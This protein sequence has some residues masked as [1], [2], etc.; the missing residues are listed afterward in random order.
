ME[1]TLGHLFFVDS[2]KLRIDF[3]R[4]KVL[5]RNNEAKDKNLDILD[6]VW[7]NNHGKVLSPVANIEGADNIAPAIIAAFAPSANINSC[8]SDVVVIYSKDWNQ[9]NNR[10]KSLKEAK[11]CQ[12]SEIFRISYQQVLN[13][14]Q[15]G[16]L[17]LTNPSAEGPLYKERKAFIV[18]L[19]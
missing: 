18:K 13:K 17:E 8:F 15:D 4:K 2:I 19:L 6:T 3:T 9:R 10:F 16:L 12:A 1:D 7:D 5:I 11:D 14:D